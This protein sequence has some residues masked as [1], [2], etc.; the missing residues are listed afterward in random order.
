VV[1]SM[2]V[3]KFNAAGKIFHLDIYLQRKLEAAQ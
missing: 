3:Y 1:N 2:S